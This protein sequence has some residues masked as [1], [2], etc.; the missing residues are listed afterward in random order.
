[1]TYSKTPVVHVEVKEMS[2][3]VL[4]NLMEFLRIE[5]IVPVTRPIYRMDGDKS[6]Y[7]GYFAPKAA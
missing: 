5:V 7:S 1:M 2:E 4:R 6:H 3:D